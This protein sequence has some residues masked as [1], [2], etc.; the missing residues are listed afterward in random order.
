MYQIG[1][2]EAGRGPAI[3]PL[4]VC[5]LG[6]P[7]S[8][9]KFLASIGAVDSKQIT[10]KKR[11]EISERIYLEAENRN[12]KIGIIVCKASRIDIERNKINLNK[13]E[14]ELFKEAVYETGIK[15]KNGIVKADACDVNEQRFKERIRYAL[16]AKWKDWEIHARHKMDSEEIIV[17]AASILAKVRRDKE[18]E[19]ISDLLNLDVGSGYPSDPKT[20]EAVKKLV[21]SK[22][23]N[24][25]L[26]WSWATVK[27]AWNSTHDLPIPIREEFGR[28]RIQSSLNEWSNTEM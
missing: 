23:P 19:K 5:A 2:D 17:G 28:T 18:I 3:G 12:W 26:R 27:N 21:N 7:N 10:R 8:D 13:L 4:V 6:I 22:T 20:K 1:I 9:T 24:Q 14:I 25:Y 11:E 16:G 15:E